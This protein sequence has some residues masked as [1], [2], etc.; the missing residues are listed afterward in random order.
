MSKQPTVLIL[1]EA[2]PQMLEQVRAAGAGNVRI[3]P[4]LDRTGQQV[5]KELLRG[6][7]CMLCEL[8]PSNLD[9]ADRLKWI[10]LTSAGYSQI[11]GLP[12]VERAIRVTNG[13]A[14][15]ISPSPNGTS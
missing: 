1:L 2:N 4:H 8:L 14:T 3:G 7:E 11:F 10:Q 9:D 13:R 15:L 5:D 6:A 12:L